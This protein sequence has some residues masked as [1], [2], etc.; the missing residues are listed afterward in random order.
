MS[1]CLLQHL[2]DKERSIPKPKTLSTPQKKVGRHQTGML[3][4]PSIPE[5]GVR[6]KN[7]VPYKHSQVHYHPTVFD[8]R[9]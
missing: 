4:V 5:P 1:P 3:T 7:R 8:Y 6:P 9:P 2:S